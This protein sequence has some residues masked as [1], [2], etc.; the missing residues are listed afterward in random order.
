MKGLYTQMPT[1]NYFLDEN[2]RCSLHTEQ[3]VPLV[4][5]DDTK[6]SFRCSSCGNVYKLNDGIFEMIHNETLSTLG[7]FFNAEKKTMG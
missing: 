7:D 2:L 3:N 5:V 6:H 1:L 4:P